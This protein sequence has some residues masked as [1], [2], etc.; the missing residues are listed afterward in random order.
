MK[1][2]SFAGKTDSLIFIEDGFTFPS[3]SKI[4]QYR[5]TSHASYR[6]RT[7]SILEP[8]TISIPIMA[9]RRNVTRQELN[10]RLSQLLYSESPRVLSI[11]D[12]DWYVIGE[13]NGPYEI[14][15]TINGLTSFEIDFTSTYPYK[16][17]DE[18][19]TQ[20]ANKTVIIKSKTQLPTT[21][22][23]ELSNLTGSDVQISISGDS[24][25]RIRLS[26]DLPSLLTIDIENEKIYETNSGL[27]MMKLLRFDS[28]FEDFKI[29]NNDVVVVTNASDTAQAKLIYKELLL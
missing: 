2:F 23:I 1:K 15:N 12:V 3:M 6:K 28:A 10:G 19:R 9:F 25:R 13:F 21:P 8:L 26:G 16:F 24:F 7:R 14:P 4:V 22:L 29:K 18:E 5:N 17:Y 27:N 11:E 20:I